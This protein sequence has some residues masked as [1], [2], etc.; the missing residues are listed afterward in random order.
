[1]PRLIRNIEGSELTY[2]ESNIQYITSIVGVVQ[3]EDYIN[4]H[5]YVA[6]I[7]NLT[8]TEN[9]Q[10]LIKPLKFGLPNLHNIPMITLEIDY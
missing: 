1:M 3:Q 6:L 9:T 8:Q 4:L 5:G 2:I 10:G 7:Q